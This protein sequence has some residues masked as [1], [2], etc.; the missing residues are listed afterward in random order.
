MKI[1]LTLTALIVFY[2]SVGI[3]DEGDP[4]VWIYSELGTRQAQGTGF[5]F[6]PNGDILTA[7]HVIKDAHQ[8]NV[9]HKGEEFKNILVVAV[10]PEADLA[11]LKVDNQAAAFPYF[12]LNLSFQN[13]I[14]GQAITSIGHP[15]GLPNQHI[16]G[17]ITQV[18]TLDSDQFRDKDGNR[19]FKRKNLKL[20]PIDM[21]IYSGA[22]GSPLLLNGEVIGVLSGSFNEGGSIVWGIPIE[23]KDKMRKIGRRA[24]EIDW[25]P[26]KLM[27]KSWSTLRRTFLL[28]KDL[29]KFIDNY[30]SALDEFALANEK[31]FQE[32]NMTR[33]TL[34]IVRG[35]LNSVDEIPVEKR[36]RFLEAWEREYV[37]KLLEASQKL[38][39][40]SNRLVQAQGKVALS[41]FP[42]SKKVLTLL[43]GLPIT[44]RNLNTVDMFEQLANQLNADS[45]SFRLQAEQNG[46]E[47]S[48][49][50]GELVY[51][52]AKIKSPKNLDTLGKVELYKKTLPVLDRMLQRL[53]TMN[54]T[55]MQEFGWLY[56]NKGKLME[57]ALFKDFDR[58][59]QNIR[60]DSDYFSIVAPAGWTLL[61]AENIQ[62]FGY[63]PDLLSLSGVFIKTGFFGQD[64]SEANMI[65]IMEVDDHQKLPSPVIS[66]AVFRGFKIGSERSLAIAFPNL[67]NLNVSKFVFHER[68]SILFTGLVGSN[69]IPG[70][71]HNVYLNG[72]VQDIQIN[73]QVYWGASIEECRTAIGSINF[74]ELLE[75]DL[76]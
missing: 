9:Y 61:T 40:F 13:T 37:S 49:V 59:Y 48:K 76:L 28:D 38:K 60:Y 30:Y 54:I 19:L 2:S 53:A 20:L 4:V 35:I 25:Q 1:L 23:Y 18:G 71:I 47:I 67:E 68:E 57:A 56:Q 66:E 7:Y 55:D 36:E 73:C 51:T 34:S 63:N 27:A 52:M 14:S 62:R 64:S 32:I 16:Q 21:N 72:P 65:A 29:K 6:S 11:H 12:P 70:R 42:I 17:N 5:F 33:G 50:H 39:R 74:F 75:D 69:N 10:L 44:I 41:F 26:F 8:I 58:N 24:N 15:R 22:S 45:K 3:A 31:A 46:Q 43:D